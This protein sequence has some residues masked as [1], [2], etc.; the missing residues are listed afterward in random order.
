MKNRGIAIVLAL[1]LGGLGVHRFYL[2]QITSGF[3]MLVFFWTFIPAI[4]GLIDSIG[5][6]VIGE[7][8]FHRRYN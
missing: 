4:I 2:G 6:A 3:F 7:E 1:F 5:Y 8:R